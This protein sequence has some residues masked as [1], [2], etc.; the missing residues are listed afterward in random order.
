VSS[1][2][3]LDRLVAPA[4]AWLLA[5]AAARTTVATQ[6]GDSMAW[7]SGLYALGCAACELAIANVAAS[8]SARQE[9]IAGLTGDLTLGWTDARVVNRPGH[10]S[11]EAVSHNG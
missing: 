9:R 11:R 2:Q 10:T 6:S 4:M 8:R 5:A 1:H 3:D 7:Q